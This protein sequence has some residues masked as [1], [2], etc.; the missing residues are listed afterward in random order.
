M[1][2]IRRGRR[3]RVTDTSEAGLETLI[4][5]SLINEAGYTKG[6]SSGL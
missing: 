5:Q 4:E 1:S 6:K 3:M 2:A